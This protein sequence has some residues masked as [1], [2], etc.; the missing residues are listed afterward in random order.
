VASPEKISRLLVVLPNWLGDL[1]MATPTLAAL[2]TGLPDTRIS[3]LLKP[4]LEEIVAGG[5]WH[6]DVLAWPAERGLSAI[7]A[8]RGLI[9]AL[10]SR[11]FDAAILLANS[12]RAALVTAL[13]RVPLRVGYAREGRGLLLTKPLKPPRRDGDFT[14]TPLSPYYAKLAE[15]VACAPADLRSRLALSAEQESATQLLL[16]AHGLTAGR[17]A[18]IAP[19]AAFGAAKCW[20]PQRFAEVA[21]R[22]RESHALETA[23]VGAAREMPLLREIARLSDGAARVIENPGTTLGTLKGVLRGAALLVCNDSGPRHV[24]RAFD[25]PTL[26]I[27]GP[28]HQEWTRCEAGREIALQAD[29]PCGPCQLRVCPIDHRCMTAITTDD[30]LAGIARLSP[31]GALSPRQV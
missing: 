17:Y 28:T 23:V 30:V 1:V 8:T 9:C 13:A 20:L 15:C 10:A 4:P 11:K 12:F 24:G 14:P 26:V 5:N 22:V 27:F 6:D 31:T 25:V 3:Y 18:V 29:V 21:R 7:P 2:R 19:G 16:A